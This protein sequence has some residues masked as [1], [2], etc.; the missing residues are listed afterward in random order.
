[1]AVVENV[2]VDIKLTKGE[3]GLYD[4]NIAEDGDFEAA[5]GYDT[6]I[7]NDA[8]GERRADDNEVPFSLRRRGWIGNENPGENGYQYGSTLWFYYQARKTLNT[9]NGCVDSLRDAFAH[10]VPELLQAVIITGQ[11]KPEGIELKV[12]MV[13]KNGKTDT[14]YFRLWELT[15]N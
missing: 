8:L 4:A 15:G 7:L 1:M 3:D 6:S 13:R 5:Y 9:K 12:K 14:L 10:Y 2:K 11:L